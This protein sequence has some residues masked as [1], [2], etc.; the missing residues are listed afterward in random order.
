[1]NKIRRKKISGS[2]ELDGGSLR[3]QLQACAEDF[4]CE[5]EKKKK[6]KKKKNRDKLGRLIGIVC[7]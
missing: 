6:K 4:F 1:M 7:L 3:V 5:F 2:G